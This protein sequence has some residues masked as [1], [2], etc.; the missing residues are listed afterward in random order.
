MRTFLIALGSAL[1]LSIVACGDGATGSLDAFDSPNGALDGGGSIRR[2]PSSGPST[3][4]GA[5]ARTTPEPPK[6]CHGKT[7]CGTGDCNATTHT[8][9]C[10]G[11][12]VSAV[13]V[14][15]NLFI[16]LDRSCSMTDDVGG[17]E[18]KWTAAVAALTS[19]TTTYEKDVRFGM[20]LF[21]DK[22][23]DAC[24]QGQI[25]VPVGPNGAKSI[26]QKL[27]VALNPQEM[28]FPSGPCSTNIDTGVLQAS[29]QEPAFADK[30]RP[31][32][33][34][35][36]TDGIQSND[37]GGVGSNATTLM[38]VQ[39]LAARGVG[40]FVVGFGSGVD[41][42]FM[43]Q[44]AQAGGHPRVGA[45][46]AYYDAA[47]LPSLSTALATIGQASLSCDLKLAAPPPNGDPSLLFVFF[48]GQS[49]GIAR[50]PS[51]ANGWDYDAAT[52][53]I[54]F[55]GATCAALRSGAV[56][57]ESVVV[58]CGAGGVA[59]TPR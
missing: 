43:D 5:V 58:G 34:V 2:D 54:R 39:S 3:D 48:D 49:P 59:P 22:V 38:A 21:P 14:Q 30:S 41:D 36:V 4:G 46:H 18:T 33:V 55:F 27:T 23:G 13:R 35:L 24:T 7:D 29:T 19:L 53:S 1:L 56:Q 40:T 51:H 28:L 45:A 20:T 47:D 57:R 37:C 16:V 10:G 52:T 42:A 12:D 31:S 17:G 9:T 8:C 44:L 26:R 15:S 50:D 32:S 11:Q 6:A 25:P